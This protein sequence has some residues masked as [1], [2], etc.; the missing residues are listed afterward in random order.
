MEGK[1]FFVYK[2]IEKESA[3]N[4]SIGLMR[5]LERFRGAG[6]KIM[7]PD[8]HSTPLRILLV[9]DS[10]QVR[11]V[12]ERALK[13]SGLPFK[14]TLCGRAEDIAPAI[15][16]DGDAFDV[17][18]LDDELPGE[19]GLETYL[20]LQR[21]MS[22]PPFVMLAGAGSE[23]LAVNAMKAGF[24]DYIVKDS[25]QGYLHLLPLK[26]ADVKKRCQDRQARLQGKAALEKAYAE[27]EQTVKRRTAD[28]ARTV[29][30]LQDEINERR[31][32]E[33]ALLLSQ[34]ALKALSVKI[35][36]TQ[37]NERRM[38]SKELHDSIG[39]SLAAIKFALE[40]KMQ[41]EQEDPPRETISLAQVVGHLLDTIEEVRRIST[42]LR[43]SMLDDLGLLA[44][45]KWYCRKSGE[46]YA[47]TRIES[48][49]DLKEE[50]I[51]EIAK[52]VTYRVMQEALTNA[53]K[54]S[55]AGTVRVSLENQV[56]GIRLC[57]ED[58]G[59]G[60]DPD[61]KIEN[62]DSMSGYGLQ[63][64]R[65]RAEIVGGSLS[66]DSRPGTG[67]AVCLELPGPQLSAMD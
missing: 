6:E 67:T 43:P 10:E 26:L 53:L 48:R 2:A 65:D 28:L 41:Q 45:I 11:M 16:P 66:I 13:T 40:E 60:F 62:P 33:K 25:R 61:Q 58:D 24:Y 59:S 18:V 32:T 12:F 27:L 17:V 56:A 64:M 5:Y 54:H 42:S 8:I 39:G 36:E 3:S 9:E 31:R 46:M 52:I 20:T 22:L 19:N 49:F 55:G 57:V 21:E 34:Q 35:I 30:A 51:P 37:E 47:N 7:N 50:D 29:E 38:L 63:G 44:T 1:A 23:S 14:L 15:Q 4:S